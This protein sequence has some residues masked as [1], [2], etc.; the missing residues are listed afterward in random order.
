MRR[1]AYNWLKEAM[2][3]LE[4][5]IR[6]FKDK[7][8]ALSVFLSQ[9]AC[10][11]ALKALIISLLRKSPPKTHDLVRL[12][13]ELQEKVVFNEDIIEKLPEVS[14]YYITARYP[15]AALELPSESISEEQASRALSVAEVI[16]N[17]AKRKIS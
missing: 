10:E 2:V 8:Y 13:R 5:A 15:N 12:Y 17:E 4:R 6:S 14:Q 16:I 11:K 1:E 7:D 9:Q 3:D